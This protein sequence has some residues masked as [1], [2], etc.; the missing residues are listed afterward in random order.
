MFDHYHA[1]VK[2][3]TQRLQGLP[4]ATDIADVVGGSTFTFKV[5]PGHP[6]Y[7]E[8]RGTLRSLRER[9]GALRT[10]VESWNDHNDGPQQS[11]AVTVYAGQCLAEQGTEPPEEEHEKES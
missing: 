2:T 4:S 7:D 9:L 11:Q 10:A 1:V 6:H 5:W 8:V 3:I